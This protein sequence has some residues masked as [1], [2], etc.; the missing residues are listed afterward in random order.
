[1][2]F[3]SQDPRDLLKL[4]FNKY[5]FSSISLSKISGIE[6]NVILNYAKGEDDL[7]SSLDVRMNLDEIVAMLSLGMEASNEN[8][9]VQAILDYL[10]EECRIPIDTISI[11]AK[12]EPS[13]INSFLEDYNSISY[14]KRYRLG[15][16]VLF[17]H[18][19]CK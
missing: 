19:I 5:K 17:L 9:R 13:D 4:L 8:E 6:E 16:T 7:S 3:Q 11:Y 2:T 1:L 15:I 12:L 10:L 18:Y 14:E